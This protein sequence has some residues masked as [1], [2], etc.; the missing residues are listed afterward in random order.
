MKSRRKMLL[1]ILIISI[2]SIML[3]VNYSKAALQSNGGSPATK[4]INDWLW[5]IRTM[6]STGGTLGLSD[7][8]AGNL[9]SGNKNLDIHMQKNTEYGALVILGTSAYGNLNKIGNGE[10]T[11]GNQTGVVMR[12]NKE[13]VVGAVSNVNVTNFKNA[14]GR[15]KNIYTKD[16]VS[17]VGDALD[18]GTWHGN[19]ANRWFRTTSNFIIDSAL[20]RSYTT[21]IFSYYGYGPG[22]GGSGAKDA[23][24]TLPWASRAVVVVG[25]GI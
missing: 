17:K 3:K 11:T 9:T 24:V 7:T 21:S 12:I 25:S 8:I 20:L 6:Q 1:A 10:T 19:A 22:A 13:W 18:I 2:V 14:V 5:Q 4:S 23:D 15:Y 16:L